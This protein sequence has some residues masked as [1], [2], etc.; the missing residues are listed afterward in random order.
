LALTS[1]LSTAQNYASAGDNQTAIN[2]LSAPIDQVSA[3]SG[4]H[5]AASAASVLITD[6]QALQTSGANLRPDPVVG[7]VVNSSN[8]AIA[9]AAINVLDPSNAVVATA[10]TDNTGFYF[11]PLTRAW[12][13]GAV[14]TVKVTV[15]KGYKTS[16]PASQ[17]FIWQATQVMISNFVLN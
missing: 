8:V 11:F 3:P 12:T 15:P 2:V 6:T 7:Y 14:Y 9:G 10:V 17:E 1:K 4:K 13:P 5:V 16:T